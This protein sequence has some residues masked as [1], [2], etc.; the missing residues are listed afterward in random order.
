MT[1]EIIAAIGLF[2]V[3][4]IGVFCLIGYIAYKDFN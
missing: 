4:P 3:I 2:I 1:V